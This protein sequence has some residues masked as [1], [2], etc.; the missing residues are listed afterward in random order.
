MKLNTDIKTYL[1]SIGA[2]GGKAKSSKKTLANRK[3]A[4]LRWD[5]F[6]KRNDIKKTI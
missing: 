4:Q 1:A 6:F 2:K 3:N 5:R